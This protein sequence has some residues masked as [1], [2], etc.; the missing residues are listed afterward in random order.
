ML[1]FAVEYAPVPVEKREFSFSYDQALKAVMKSWPA[2]WKKGAIVDFSEC[3]DPRAKEL[4]RRTVLSQYLTAINCAGSMPPQET[5]LTTNSWFG[6]PHLEMTWWHA[7]DFALW[8]RPSVVGKML[9][10]YNDVA[11][12]EARRI[13][14]R[15]G[16][17]GVRWMKM[18]DP[19]PA[20]LPPIQVHS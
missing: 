8:N 16:F 6:R 1:T 12:P 17:A 15:Q 18:T 9:D 5:G 7:V 10:W 19:L 20:R 3:T 2:F 4:E 13:A 14:S 11:Y